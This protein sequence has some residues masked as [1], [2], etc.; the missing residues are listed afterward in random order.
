MHLAVRA[1]LLD[2]SA[3]PLHAGSALRFVDDGVLL[4]DD[5]LIAARGEFSALRSRIDAHTRL[6]DYSGCL[7]TPGFVD[8]HIHMP[9]VDVIASPAAGLLD[10]LERH[11]FPAEARFADPAVAAE[12]ARFFLDELA[13]HG[14]TSALVFGT[15]HAASIE[16]LFEEGLR[17]NVRLIGGKCLMDRFCP[18]P[19]RDT[20]EG[21]V[22]ESA[23]LAARWHGR[24]RL[25]YA[26]T[27]RFAATS[28]PRQLG[29]AGELARSRPELYIQSHVAE[30]LD[31]IRWVK[32]LFPEARSY[33]DVYDRAGLLRERAVYAHCIWLDGDDRARMRA[34][35]AAAAV[36]PTSN[37]FLGSGLFDFRAST[38]AGMAITLATDVGGGQSFSMLATM[39]AA[40]DVARLKG[41]P[42]GAAQLW[43]WATRG[44][45][46]ALGWEDRAGALEAGFD[47]DFVVLDPRAT[48]LLARRTGRA[49]SP[50]ELLFALLV[51]GD[52]RAV[53]E[54]F[55]AGRAGK[56]QVETTG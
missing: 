21:G 40:H 33:L 35:G 36:C 22:Q 23:D 24:G 44:G 14:T 34:S 29:L 16:A 13:R 15:S 37:L 25:A 39:R 42:L 4:V 17:R 1:S 52:D 41:V 5:G 27:P 51:L 26:I 20:A 32:E 54:T 45:A 6:L 8:T 28:T 56:P 47:A 53:R 50:E 43:Y 38:D 2:F 9:Q 19:L 30:N 46:R 18:E 7:V 11:T 48:P 49:E 12:A 10:W 3:D 55:I 31:E